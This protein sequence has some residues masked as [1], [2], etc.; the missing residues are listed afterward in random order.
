MV[1]AIRAAVRRWTDDDGL[2]PLA[3][4]AGEAL[5]ALAAGLPQPPP[6][7]AVVPG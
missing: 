1:G 3:D 7:R 6:R 5:D 4:L 2:T